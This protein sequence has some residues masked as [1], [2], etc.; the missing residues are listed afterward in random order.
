MDQR[1][2]DRRVFRLA[3]VVGCLA[4]LCAL[5][6]PFSAGAQA[7]GGPG[8]G[9][10]IS[11][12]T[13]IT[14]RFAGLPQTGETVGRPEAP[15]RIVAFDDV[16][17][18]ACAQ[19]FRTVIPRV[20]RRYVRS[21]RAKLTLRPLAFV[22]PSSEL[23]AL[24]A[25]A[26]ARQNAIWPFFSLLLANQGSEGEAWLDQ[27]RMEEAAGRLGLDVALWRA[28][29]LSDAVAALHFRNA[30]LARIYRVDATPTFIVRGPRGARKVIG[31]PGIAAF[32]RAIAEVGPTPR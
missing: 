6:M 22:G 25:Q 24:G 30:R 19:A 15:V 9:S 31:A 1:A 12:A 27:G 5:A 17:C 11:G 8:S 13:T 29:Y 21:G 10:T 28:D 20:L 7:P 4:V 2:R 3:L 14:A 18:P 32:A 23:G 26:A 16:S